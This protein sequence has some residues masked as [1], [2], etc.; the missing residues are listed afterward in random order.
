MA[1]PFSATMEAYLAYA[2]SYSIVKFLI[3]NY[4]QDKMFDLLNT[5]EQGSGYDEALEKVYGFNMDGLNVL[6]RESVGAAAPATAGAGMH[7][8]L[9]GASAGVLLAAGFGVRR[10][11][12]S[13]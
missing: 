12:R 5:F 13:H 8:A 6:W 9:I 10:W 2:Q 1:S 3:D 7:P 11:R 4:G